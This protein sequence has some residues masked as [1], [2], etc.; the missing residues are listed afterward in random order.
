[1]VKIMTGS[2]GESFSPYYQ[3]LNMRDGLATH[4][5][6]EEKNTK[7]LVGRGLVSRSGKAG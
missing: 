6:A 7:T 3:T 4:C 5:G 2:S 1:V